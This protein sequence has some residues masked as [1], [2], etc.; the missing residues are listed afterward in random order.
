MFQG[1]VTASDNVVPNVVLVQCFRADPKRGKVITNESIT[2]LERVEGQDA[3][4]SL[5]DMK[6]P[7]GVGQHQIEVTIV[8]LSWPQTR[9]VV[10]A[11]GTAEIEE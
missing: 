1:N 9:Q 2:R 3:W 4:T 8:Q 5:I 7:Q 6:A 10:I 11:S